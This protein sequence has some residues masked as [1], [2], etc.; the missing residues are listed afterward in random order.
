MVADCVITNECALAVSA[1]RMWKV[2]CSG[3][4]LLKACAD[5]FVAVNVEGD[6]GPGSV[7]TSTLSAA[8]AAASGGSFVRDRVVARDDAARVLRTEVLEGGKVR[9]QL[10]FL[11][12]EVKFEV[13]GD[14]ACV[15]KFRVEYERIDGDG[16]LAPEDQAV[17]VEGYL[18]I[19]KAIEA[20][21]VTNPSEYA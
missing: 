11:V 7:I 13:A 14:D 17:I 16:A 2:S 9:N 5:F 18:G 21:L 10:K 4:T 15:A 6:G 20:Y 3:E 19:L 8:A 1:E 12:N